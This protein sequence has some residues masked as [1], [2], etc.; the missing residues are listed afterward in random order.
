MTS[1]SQEQKKQQRILDREEHE[2]ARAAKAKMIEK[3]A[4]R[5]AKEKKRREKEAKKEQKRKEKAI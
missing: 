4:K 3:E 1:F 2:K 5:R